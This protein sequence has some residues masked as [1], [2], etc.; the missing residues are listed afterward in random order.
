MAHMFGM[1][2]AL[3][4]MLA[5]EQAQ[6]FLEGMKTLRVRYTAMQ[7]NAQ[8]I[9][10]ILSNHPEVE[11]VFYPGLDPKYPLNG[12]MKG[13]GHMVAF[14]LKKG[15]EGGR[16]FVDALQLITNAVSMG[17]VESLTQVSQIVPLSL[18]S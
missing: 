17:G 11:A 7:A 10:E 3:G 14:V 13:P 16:A 4:G 18:N 5:P 9:A 12:Q 15:L 2:N 1:R 6:R 8:T